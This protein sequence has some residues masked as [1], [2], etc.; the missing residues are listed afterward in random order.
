MKVAVK[1]S[2]SQKLH[3][4]AEADLDHARFPK[5]EFADPEEWKRARPIIEEIVAR[6]IRYKKPEVSSKQL[7]KPVLLFGAFSAVC[8]CDIARKHH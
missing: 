4:P 2:R 6:L 8:G 1:D 3:V 5:T 7:F